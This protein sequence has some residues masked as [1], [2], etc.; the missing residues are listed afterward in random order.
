MSVRGRAAQNLLDVISSNDEF[1]HAVSVSQLGL[2]VADPELGAVVEAINRRAVFVARGDSFALHQNVVQSVV[3]RYRGL[4]EA[5]E[6][7]AIGFDFIAAEDGSRQ[8]SRRRTNRVGVQ[9]TARESRLI[10]G[11]LIVLS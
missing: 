7:S 3:S 6:R 10:P 2:D 4:V 11:W 5:A 1:P 9:Q 8:S